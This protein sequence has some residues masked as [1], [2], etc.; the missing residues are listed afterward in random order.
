MCV[1]ACVNVGVHLFGK[2]WENED[3]AYILCLI[4]IWRK[5][6]TVD[7]SVCFLKSGN[8]LSFKTPL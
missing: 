8:D 3:F 6:I 7:T 2:G 4:T 1:F 5:K